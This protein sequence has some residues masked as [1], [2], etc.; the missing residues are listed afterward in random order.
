M[1]GMKECCTRWR[2]I[3]T[4]QVPLMNNLICS[5]RFASRDVSVRCLCISRR[6]LAPVRTL[7]PA[8]T[9]ASALQLISHRIA[10]ILTLFLAL[11][12]LPAD[13]W[14]PASSGRFSFDNPPLR[15]EG[16]D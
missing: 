9:G 12:P 5:R 3:E 13:A 16:P 1:I 8:P 7:V 6:A 11:L 10:L 2:R 14:Q 15:Y 4:S